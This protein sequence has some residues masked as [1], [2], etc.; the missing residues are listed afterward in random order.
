MSSIPLPPDACSRREDEP[1]QPAARVAWVDVSR[2]LVMLGTIMTHAPVPRTWEERLWFTSAGRMCL[3]FAFAGYF[4]ARRCPPG[5]WFPQMGRAVRM[6]VA[7]VLLVVVYVACLGWSPYWHWQDLSALESGTWLERL[8]LA[9][10][11]LGMGDYP[12]GPLWFLRDLL[13]L[14]LACGFFAWLGRRRW[15]YPMI[16]VCL[17]FGVE[18]ACH[19]FEIAGW[20]L[21]HPREIAFF[22]LG[23][24]L[25]HV[26]LSSI[27]AWLKRWWAPMVI[28]ALLLLWYEP[29]HWD[30]LTPAGIAAYMGLSM[31]AA[32]WLEHL[33]P[34]VARLVARLGETVFFVYVLHMLV[35]DLGTYALQQKFGIDAARL[36]AWLWLLV[37]P[38]IYGL[39]HALGMGI[40]RRSPR[41]FELLA[42]RPP[43]KDPP[44][45]AQA[46]APVDAAR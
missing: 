9:R 11:L 22:G 18:T 41:L 28:L 39:I 17:L 24:A 10:R 1:R 15:L 40:K 4:M 5:V 12:P 34:R 42:I 43:R 13:L 37:V 3:L 26:P 36:P 29:R 45:G 2:V 33:L 20:E 21:L 7:Y 27:A 23:A 30:L 16:A 44:L 35:I 6:L 46:G 25:T 19:R 32:L 38:A 14:T 31:V 8:D